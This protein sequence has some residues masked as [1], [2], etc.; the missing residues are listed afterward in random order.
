MY[1]VCNG[2]LDEEEQGECK[3]LE[4]L[5][6]VYCLCCNKLLE[7]AALAKN[8]SPEFKLVTVPLLTGSFRYY[9]QQS[10]ICD[11]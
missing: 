3:W 1:F 4:M 8:K 6:S 10:N 2:L 5:H 11:I 9:S 7:A